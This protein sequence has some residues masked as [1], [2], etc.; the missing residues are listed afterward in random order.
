MLAYSS[1]HVLIKT[2]RG[3]LPKHKKKKHVKVVVE[4]SFSIRIDKI[5]SKFLLLYDLIN[6]NTAG[7][8]FGIHV[9]TLY[10]AALARAL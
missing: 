7:F 5:W 10:I 3:G 1:L 2:V 6:N 9:T 8:N 4:H